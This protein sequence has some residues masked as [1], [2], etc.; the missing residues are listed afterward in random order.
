MAGVVLLLLAACSSTPRR[1]LTD[2]AQ[3]ALF[4]E[5]QEA[6]GQIKSWSLIGRLSVDDGSD[7][8]SGRLQWE[9]QGPVYDLSF[10]GALGKGAWQLHIEPGLAQLTKADGSVVLADSVEQLVASELGWSV[11][12]HALRWWAMGLSAPGRV[13]GLELDEFGRAES[14]EQSGWKVSFSRYKDEAGHELPGRLDAI[15]GERR[16]KLAIASWQALQADAARP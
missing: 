3:L 15:S 13:S 6:L 7:G 16:V 12:V 5:R 2:S 9:V 10:R 11:P 8:G 4:E 14:L 1:T